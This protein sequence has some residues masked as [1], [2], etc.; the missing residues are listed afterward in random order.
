MGF[1]IKV[2]ILFQRVSSRSSVSGGV[3]Q[4]LYITLQTDLLSETVFTL[5]KCKSKYCDGKNIVSLNGILDLVPLLT[6]YLTLTVS[7]N[8]F[9]PQFLLL[10]NERVG[11]DDL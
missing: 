7:F 9:D 4:I 8:L 1:Y 5:G 10:Q 6:L 11:L 3:Q 2:A